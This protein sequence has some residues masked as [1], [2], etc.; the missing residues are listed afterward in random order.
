MEQVKYLEDNKIFE[1]TKILYYVVSKE[2]M[3]ERMKT[4]ALTSGRADD[5]EETQQKR[6]RT[7]F[8]QTEP[9]IEYYEKNFAEKLVKIEA[10]AG[11]DEVY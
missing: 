7:Y 9:M 6:V 2:L 11:V 10:T 5:N 3:L 8:E 4:R 1:P